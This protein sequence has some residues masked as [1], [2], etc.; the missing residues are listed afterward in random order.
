MRP[1]VLLADDSQTALLM[2]KMVFKHHTNY[3]VV[4]ASNGEEAV[5]RAISERPDLILL[6]AVMPK[7]DGFAACRQI[8]KAKGLESVPIVMVGSFAETSSIEKGYES[9]CDA[10]LTKPLSADDLLELATSRQLGRPAS[11][12]EGSHD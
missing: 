10:Y 6:D 4:T 12:R 5:S 7:M 9:G 11:I 3:D 1:K 2:E 8:R